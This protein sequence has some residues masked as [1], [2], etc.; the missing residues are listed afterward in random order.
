M[1]RKMIKYIFLHALEVSALS[2]AWQGTQILTTHESAF[3][4]VLETED[5]SLLRLA[6]MTEYL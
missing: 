2:G 5:C 1:K 3:Q 6:D 4:A